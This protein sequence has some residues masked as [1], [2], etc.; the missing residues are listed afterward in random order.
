MVGF[1]NED[2]LVSDLLEKLEA[3]STAS[4]YATTPDDT[5]AGVIFT[6]MPENLAADAK[7]E[8]KLRFPSTARTSTEKNRNPFSTETGWQTEI[9]FPIFGDLGPRNLDVASGSPPRSC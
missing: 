4:P 2:T 9:T 7:I 1:E 6:R 8:Y 5:L 3:A